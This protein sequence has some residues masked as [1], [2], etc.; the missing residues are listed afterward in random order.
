MAHEIDLMLP[1]HTE[2]DLSPQFCNP[3]ALVMDASTLVGLCAGF[4]LCIRLCAGLL[5]CA[6][7]VNAESELGLLLTKGKRGI[8]LARKILC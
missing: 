3:N 2:M 8:V 5:A 4:Q 7:N 6:C 1:L